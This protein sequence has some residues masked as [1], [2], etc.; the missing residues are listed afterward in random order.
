ML[1]LVVM[2]SYVVYLPIKYTILN[3]TLTTYDIIGVSITIILNVML[4]IAVSLITYL[5]LKNSYDDAYY[6]I[7]EEMRIEYNAKAIKIV[8]NF[9]DK[10]YK[11]NDT[12]IVVYVSNNTYNI[13]KNYIYNKYVIFKIDE[14]RKD[15][16]IGLH[17]K[18]DLI[19]EPIKFF[20][21]V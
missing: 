9:V 7:T 16:E 17:K 11:P 6:N 19:T 8:T 1:A 18:K 3:E 14:D 10:L 5:L 15:L 2:L 21:N 13:V 20:E 12:I 4:L